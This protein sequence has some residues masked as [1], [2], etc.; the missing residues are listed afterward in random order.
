MAVELQE[1]PNSTPKAVYFLASNSNRVREV[2]D[3][4]IEQCDSRSGVQARITT[5]S[6][7][8]RADTEEDAMTHI[9]QEAKVGSRWGKN[10]LEYYRDFLQSIVDSVDEPALEDELIAQFS[11]YDTDPYES[12]FLGEPLSL[13]LNLSTELSDRLNTVESS[14]ATFN[15]T[16]LAAAVGYVVNDRKIDTSV[17]G[18]IVIEFTEALSAATEFRKLSYLPQVVQELLLL[19]ISVVL[20]GPATE[21]DEAERVETFFRSVGRFKIEEISSIGVSVPQEV[22][23]WIDSWYDQLCYDVDSGTIRQDVARNAT[24]TAID[25]RHLTPPEREYAT[26]FLNAIE[27]GLQDQYSEQKLSG[28]H[29]SR[30]DELWDEVVKPHPNYDHHRSQRNSFPRVRVARK[31][32]GVREFVLNHDGPLLEPH[33]NGVPI[34]NNCDPSDALVETIETF[35]DAER[36]DKERW[37]T[38]NDLTRRRVSGV[39]DMSSEELLDRLLLYQGLLPPADIANTAST[40]E[41]SAVQSSGSFE[42]EWYREHW[43]AILS[44]HRVTSQA[45]LRLIKDKQELMETLSGQEA[46]TAALYAKL[47]RDV[48]HAW[49][50]YADALVDAIGASITDDIV[51]DISEDSDE[52]SIMLDLQARN[53]RLDKN[54]TVE[55]E[56]YMPYRD[57]RVDEREVSRPTISNTT[58]EV[59]NS[60]A[61]IISSESSQSVSDTDELLYNL[62]VL[63]EETRTHDTR[64]LMYFDDFIE[65]CL[66]IPE[67]SDMFQDSNDSAEEGLRQALGSQSLKRRLER[68]GSTYHRKGT[69]PYTGVKV[70]SD[71]YVAVELQVPDL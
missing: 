53:T 50:H 24:A 45:G 19:G 1:W 30:F 29:R 23:S 35:L 36:V 32:G 58:D 12:A 71:R 57:V 54:E 44:S 5:D 38:L 67:V 26:H 6:L 7:L 3:K 40:T 60:L 14:S 34:A 4:V 68:T 33:L 66:T 16:D 61:G 49:E 52:S 39:T 42:Q 41:P 17:V 25:L 69:D 18:T 63:Y 56:V 64:N 10:L 2:G 28:A 43:Q 51:L 47:K 8:E 20:V 37:S 65:F 70:G 62:I 55:I 15:R 27:Y 13:G 31:D 9:L 59:L 48:E 22:D 11:K 46:S 21:T